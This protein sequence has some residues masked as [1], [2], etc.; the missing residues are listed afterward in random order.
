MAI[1]SA[2]NPSRSDALLYGLGRR[3]VSA[4]QA[5]PLSCVVRL[6]RWG[7]AL[8]YLLDGRHRRVALE[9][10]ERCFGRDLPPRALRALAREN[11]RRIGENY[12]AAVRTA[13]MT[14][15]EILGVLETV[16]T[17]HLRQPPDRPASSVVVA[18]GHFGNFELYAR[19]SLLL[20]GYVGATTY[21]ALRS[22]GLDRLLRELR[23]RSGCLYFERRTDG[24][25]IRAAMRSQRLM[26][27]FLAD[28]H[29]GHNGIRVPFLGIECSTSTAPAVFALRYHCPLHTAICY[30]VAPG[31]W[32]VEVGP[33]IPTLD[34]E[35]R[36][37]AVEAI[38]LDMNR[39]FEAAVRRDPANWFWVHRRWKTAGAR[40]QSSASTPAPPP[41]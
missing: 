2:P 37:R 19:A 24:E 17:E 38:C 9:N 22:P 10:L 11:F 30:R 8:A 16:G 40:S 33:A 4:I 14:D 15:D 39:A 26:I 35:G 28:Q 13:A 32:R 41:A 27:G 18:I 21:R 7:G 34:P 20:P 36:R 3:V 29:A 25:A 31:R 12:A 5:L 23:T 1:P 6:G